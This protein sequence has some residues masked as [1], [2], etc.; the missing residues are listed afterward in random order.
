MTASGTRDVADADA[1]RQ[2]EAMLEDSAAQPAHLRPTAFWQQASER[3]VTEL[4]AHGFALFRRLPSALD[5]FVPTYGAPGNSL[6]CALVDALLAVTASQV[7]EGSKAWH[8]V[9]AALDGQAWA[10]S[11]YRVLLAGD[12]PEQSPDLS[13]IS[14]SMTG[15][16]LEQVVF[17][18]RRFSRTMLNYLHGLVFFKQVAG[19]APLRTVLEV[20]GGFGTLGEILLQSGSETAYIDVDIPPTAAVAAFYLGQLAGARVRGYLETRYA[21]PLPV[22]AERAQMVLCPWQLPRLEG[23]VD[24]FWNF[25]SFQEMEPE[26]VAFYLAEARRLESRFVLL[27]NLREGKQVRT[28]ANA[29]GVDTPTLG[30]DYDRWLPD[31]DL[32]ATNVHPF[33]YRTVD[34]FH[35]EL[36]LYA[37]R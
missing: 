25:I 33:G 22:P 13:A 1:L 34:G 23:R 24:L 21:Q 4:R 8:T 31:Y 16:P 19:D 18:G 26:V 14:E 37:R 36:R 6:D 7:P 29:V 20:G 11:D 9:K 15:A 35:S 28:S 30:S 32:V 17:D 12:R 5:Y 2:L 3:I 27:R 10:L